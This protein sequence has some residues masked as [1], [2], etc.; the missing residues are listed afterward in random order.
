MQIVVVRTR[1]YPS[2]LSIWTTK[3]VGKIKNRH[4]AGCVDSGKRNV[5]V[6]R[7]SVRQFVCLSRIFSDLTGRAACIFN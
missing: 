1:T 2:D 7:P 6:W 4:C 5:T 3:V